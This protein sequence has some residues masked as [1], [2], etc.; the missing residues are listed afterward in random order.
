MDLFKTPSGATVNAT[1]GQLVEAPAPISTESLTT[2]EKALTTPQV[3]SPND[4]SAFADTSLESL[5]QASQAPTQEEANMGDFQT[6]ILDITQR[7][8]GETARTEE[9]RQKAG[10][11]AQQQELQNIVN[12][13]QALQKQSAAIPLQT[14]EEFAGTGATRGGVAPIEE[15]RKRQNT[16]EALRLSAIGQTLQGNIQ[17]AE[18][19]IQNAIR[20]E[21]E[22]L[23]K[24]LNV[25]GTLYQ[26]NKEA[27]ERTDKKRAD[28]LGFALNERER[29]L[30]L[31]KL[32]KEEIY[33]IGLKAKQFGADDT[34]VQG[35]F[36]AKNPQEAAVNAGAF[37]QDPAAKLELESLRLGNALKR[38]QI[39]QQQLET[40]L[41]KRYGGLTPTQ[42]AAELKDQQKAIEEAKTEEERA[43]LQTDSLGEKATLINGIMNSSAIDS[44]VG[45]NFLTRTPTSIL[46]N[47]AT[48]ATVAGI[49]SVVGGAI[50]NIT[51]ERQNFIAGV[52]QLI[53][54]EFL[55]TLINVKA[56][57]ASF[58]AL[59]KP[60]QD[61]LTQSKSKIGTW[62]VTDDNGKVLGYA[63]SESDFKKE[64]QRFKDLT[65]LAKQR[66]G[67]KL[68]DSDEEAIL[69]QVQ[70]FDPSQF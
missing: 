1:T 25:L 61:A 63:A 10:L 68:I 60:E 46:G 41:L 64:L 5:I 32:D 8:G 15:S 23:Q 67:G 70:S 6:K 2:S 13:M 52:E 20:A 65:V 27:L 48:L 40:D 31:R 21:F 12:Q 56:Q 14:Q 19:N 38:S 44:V 47:I 58:G 16:I 33:K 18:A 3:A 24:E 39:E 50:D 7:L 57:G 54:K 37:M 35:I 36:N 45:P 51:A 49:P 59:T 53:S 43:R 69:N 26:F 62:R 29:I 17:L 9:L 42:Y 55:D 4:Y 22:P 28:A 11:P 30:N 66:A 34:T